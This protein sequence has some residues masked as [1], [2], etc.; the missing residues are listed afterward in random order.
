[1]CT[2]YDS[3]AAYLTLRYAFRSAFVCHHKFGHHMSKE[4]KRCQAGRHLSPDSR[5]L[6]VCLPKVAPLVSQLPQLQLGLVKQVLC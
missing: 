4:N 1:M 3:S 2:L 5:V 6:R